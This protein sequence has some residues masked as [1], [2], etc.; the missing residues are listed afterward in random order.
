MAI[1]KAVSSKASIGKA[2]DYVEKKEKTEEKLLEGIECNPSTAAIEMEAVKKAWGKEDGRQY[3]HFVYSFP[4]GEKVS[5]EQIRDNARKLVEETKAFKGHQVLIAVHDD[6]EHKHAHVIVN[7]VN[8]EDGHKLQ[9]SKAD[10]KSIK[11]RCNELSRSQGLS[12]PEK[13]Q[14]VTDWSLDKHKTLEKAFSGDYKSYVLD[15]ANTVADVRQVATS[16]AEFIELMKSKGIETEWKD[17]HKNIT[18]KT[19][20]GKKVRNSNLTKTFKVDFGKESLENEFQ[21]NEERIR[22][23]QRAREQLNGADGTNKEPK[24]E[25]RGIDTGVI[26]QT[27]N[28]RQLQAVIIEAERRK[29]EL[30]KAQQERTKTEKSIS[31]IEK[32]D[33]RSKERGFER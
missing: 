5:L 26:D 13:S 2:I 12:V 15:V 29:R 10:L 6:R 23:T 27:I 7:S 18:F 28:A 30:A 21:F 25:D 22:T 31:V 9:W 17:S 20:E 4:P 19:E 24:R 16:R 14:N 11:E 33:N 8:A 1:I 3:K 32:R